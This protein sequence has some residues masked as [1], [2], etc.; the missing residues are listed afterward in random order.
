MATRKPLVI[1]AGALRELPEGDVLAK[2]DVGL[3]N[4]DNTSDA[5]K[6]V[7]TAQAA[8]IAGREPA[9]TAGTT[10]QYWRGDKSWRDFFT[11]VRAATLTG[12]ST[13]TSAVITATDTV[14]T[15]A[16]KLQKQ[17][18]DHFAATANAHPAS[19]IQ[20]AAIEPATGHSMPGGSVQNLLATA[21]FRASTNSEG[22]SFH[23]EPGT[24]IKHAASAIGNT[25][26]GNIAATTVQGALNELD[27]EKVSTSVGQLGGLRNKIIN[28]NFDVWQRGTSFSGAAPEF[29]ADRW[30]APGAAGQAVTRV[31]DHPTAGSA[32]FCI[33]VA[34]TAGTQWIQQRIESNNLRDLVGKT[35]TASV[36]VKNIVPF[37]SGANLQVVRAN[38]TDDWTTTTDVGTSA[39]TASTNWT[40]LTCTFTMT[41]AMANGLML[42]LITA[43]GG[44]GAATVRLSMAQLEVGPAPTAFE[45]RDYGLELALCQ[46]Y[47]P[48][49]VGGDTTAVGIGTFRTATQLYVACHFPVEARVK[50]TGVTVT[51]AAML[52]AESG[53][54]AFVSSAIVATGAQSTKC[55]ALSVTVAGATA[56]QAA[57]VYFNGNAGASG[58]MLFTGCEL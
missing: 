24:G 57:L 9:I 22:F 26:A 29:T 33:Q 6:P 11:D 47:L 58:S 15:M 48:A 20:A 42:R 14:L 27:A 41:A 56:G 10:A 35:V 19:A 21:W 55:G 38:A 54:G 13:G 52:T 32:A 39:S 1:A 7:S 53:A 12:L 45:H 43:G 3:G 46:R 16:G 8:A 5:N 17:I 34:N 40:Q 25:P 51:S 44:G 4:V 28:G 2:A 37:G 36:W 50:P 49:V 30:F 18:S 23:V 31:A